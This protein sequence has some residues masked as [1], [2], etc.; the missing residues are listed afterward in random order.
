MTERYTRLLK[1]NHFCCNVLIVAST[2]ACWFEF[3]KYAGNKNIFSLFKLFT[4]SKKH[5]FVDKLKIE[6]NCWVNYTFIY[7]VRKIY[8][9]LYRDKNIFKNYDFL[10]TN[11]KTNNNKSI[12][13]GLQ[14]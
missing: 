5:V 9:S 11:L 12:M 10:I 6:L 14:L 7:E 3:C 4:K 1:R 13:S 8:N 2:L